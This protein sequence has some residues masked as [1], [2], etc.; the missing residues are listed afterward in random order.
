MRGCC[1]CADDAYAGT[2]VHLVTLPLWIA[3]QARNDVTLC[4]AVPTLWIPAYAGM[5]DP[6]VAS[7]Y[8]AWRRP[9]PPLWI[10]DQVRN[11]VDCR[12]QQLLRW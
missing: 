6:D 2:M 8:S 3:G 7:R 4:H 11:D 9:A 1:E 10:A 5:T 12:G